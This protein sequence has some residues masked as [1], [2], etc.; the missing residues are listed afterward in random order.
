MEPLV[1][2]TLCGHSAPLQVLTSSRDS[3]GGSRQDA[4]HYLYVNMFVNSCTVFL[5]GEAVRGLEIT[6][7][8]I[9]GNLQMANS[10]A[11]CLKTVMWQMLLSWAAAA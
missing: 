3:W 8:I 7:R 10:R 4:S 1:V 9:C 2:G 5:W 11:T 6:N